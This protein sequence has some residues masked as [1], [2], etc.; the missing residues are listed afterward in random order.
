MGQGPCAWRSAT[1]EDARA[2]DGLSRM[3]E[4]HG[5]DETAPEVAAGEN[6]RAGRLP[7][8]ALVPMARSRRWLRGEW[9]EGRFSTRGLPRAVRIL[10]ILSVAVALGSAALIVA[11]GAG[12]GLPGGTVDVPGGALAEPE[13][14]ALPQVLFVA[15]LLGIAVAAASLAFAAGLPGARAPRVTLAVVALVDAALA[16]ATI[17]SV[18]Q[19]R[20][21]EGVIEASSLTSVMTAVA[22]GAALILAAAVAIVPI[23][24]ARRRPGGVA[25]VAATPALVV[26]AV[27]LLLGTVSAPVA[28]DA[29]IGAPDF[30]AV[31]SAQAGLA[32]ALRAVAQSA[33]FLLAPFAIWQAATWAHASGGPV[34]QR[35]ADGIALRPWILWLLLTAKLAWLAAGY[36]GVLPTALGGWSPEWRESM[37]DGPIG[38][39]IAL[40]LVAIAGWWLAHPHRRRISRLGFRRAALFVAVGF[41]SWSLLMGGL[42]LLVQVADGLPLPAP[43]PMPGLER[44]GTAW[45]DGGPAYAL[46][47]LQDAFAGWILVAQIGTVLAAL[48]IGAVLLRRRRAIPIALFLLAVGVWAL[49]R[50][51]NAVRFLVF[52]DAPAGT[53]AI[54]TVELATLDTAVTL[55]VAVLAVGWWRGRGP[56]A[57]PWALGLVLV[58]VTTMTRGATLIL[59]GWSLPLFY[60]ALVFPLLYELTLD[61]EEM[62]RA[63]PD[64]SARVLQA[65]GLR[66]GALT[67]L[68][69]GLA[70]GFASPDDGTGIVAYTLFAPPFAAWLVAGVVSARARARDERRVPSVGERPPLRHALLGAG[71][72]VAIAAVLLGASA[73]VTPLVRG[74]AAVPQGSASSPAQPSERA[75]A[76]ALLNRD[77]TVRPELS[78]LA[79]PIASA[80]SAEELQ[81]VG[82]DM[83]ERARVERGWML[84]H[85]SS[86]CLGEAWE[87]RMMELTLL[88]DLGAALTGPIAD[89]GEWVLQV[90]EALVAWFDAQEDAVVALATLDARCAITAGP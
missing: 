90:E 61:S 35:A 13:P 60:V 77:R 56:R 71:A 30:P 3:A 12:V 41:A 43:S 52:G 19:I 20:V 76:L 8:W 39:G 34:G 4:P 84:A 86:G 42:G 79:D 38:W 46:L 15:L 49:P 40:A 22:G 24:W 82:R 23:R 25:A 89:E 32:P 16:G 10:V 27:Y 78:S 62:N 75:L 80:T 74:A 67:L 50:A 85:P 21:L 57:D 72:G 81:A 65:V 58:V 55:M 51:A 18:G 66:A 1:R 31:V 9:R 6:Q 73:A 83:A 54:G 70:A 33:A 26:G 69:V 14:Q 44:C 53:D 48:V 7:R 45:A 47:C 17:S 5:P 28:L 63:S 29:L 64:R 59:P 36:A 2:P 87:A 88:E 37:Q 68:F 11:L